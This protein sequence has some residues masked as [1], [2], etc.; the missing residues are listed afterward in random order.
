MN[1]DYLGNMINNF[2]VHTVSIV[3][4]LLERS[5]LVFLLGLICMVQTKLCPQQC[6]TVPLNMLGVAAVD[7]NVKEA[8]LVPLIS[9]CE[10][11]N[12]WRY[13]GRLEHEK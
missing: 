3:G 5:L 9:P 2:L 12:D 8:L 7:I 1:S 13:L 11:S 4:E 6:L 10:H